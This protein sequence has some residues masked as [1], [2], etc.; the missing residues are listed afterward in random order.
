MSFTNEARSDVPTFPGTHSGTPACLLEKARKTKEGICD[1]RVKPK[2]ERQR[3]LVVP[4][5]IKR[6]DFVT[7]LEDLKGQLGA[8]NV[9]VNDKL[10]K[11]AVMGVAVS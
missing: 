1:G 7:A 10:L 5:G 3:L 9:E 11:D 4:Q 8:D 6:D 2:R